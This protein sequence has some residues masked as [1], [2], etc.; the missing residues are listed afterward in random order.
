MSDIL[1]TIGHS[2]HDID[3]F[4]S[5]LKK[6][7][8]NHVLDVRSTPY[9]QFASN[10]NRE[11]IKAVLEMEDIKYTFMGDF[12]GARPVDRA[13]YFSDG[14]LDFDKTRKSSKFQRGMYNVIKGIH[15]GNYIALMC[16]EK[17]PIE[18]H[19]AIMV[20]RTFY[21]Y[22][23]DVEHILEDGSLQ[24]HDEL[25]HRLLEMYFPDRYQISLFSEE[26]KS[27]E[28]CLLEAY[29]YQNKKIVAAIINNSH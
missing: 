29:R 19:R 12:F 6:Y 26:N 16:T 23:I 20:S 15:D 5:M 24:S 10:Y 11:N 22:G 13:L 25:N 4:I 27:D 9:S 14:Y 18:C 1:Y 2:Q 8:I 3:Y 28:E 7:G 21:E 17:D